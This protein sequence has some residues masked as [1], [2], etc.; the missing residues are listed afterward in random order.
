M[1]NRLIGAKGK[2]KN[3]TGNVGNVNANMQTILKRQTFYTGN[4]GNVNANMLN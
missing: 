3:K 1:R 2:D 4:V